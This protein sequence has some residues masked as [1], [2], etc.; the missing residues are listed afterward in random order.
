M[1]GELEFVGDLYS[2]GWSNKYF[3]QEAVPFEFIG[4][5]KAFQAYIS[6]EGFFR[7]LARAAG[8]HVSISGLVNELVGLPLLGSGNKETLLKSIIDIYDRQDA[9]KTLMEWFQ[10]ER[11]QADKGGRHF[12]SITKHFQSDKPLFAR[13]RQMSDLDDKFVILNGAICRTEALR[14][15]GALYDAASHAGRRWVLCDFPPVGMVGE[16]EHYRGEL[17]FVEVD[18]GFEEIFGNRVPFSSDIGWFP[19][20]TVA[21]FLSAR[22]MSREQF[23]TVRMS[24]LFH[25]RPVSPEPSAKE[26]LQFVEREASH[27]IYL[28]KLS[29]RVM[30]YYLLPSM[31]RAWGIGFEHMNPQLLS[32]VSSLLEEDRARLDAGILR[33]YDDVLPRV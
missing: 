29:A 13:G 17:A 1:A 8:M 19:Y 6:Q 4:N 15:N 33:L 18:E 16:N 24:L 25:R 21:G 20:V 23:P 22:R 31:Y 3:T 14:H 26:L 10:R 11:G 27:R 7:M 28:R 5:I 12:T 2:R 30:L 32:I 9:R